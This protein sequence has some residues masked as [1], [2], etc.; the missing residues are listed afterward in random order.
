MMAE[1]KVNAGDLAWAM[2]LAAQVVEKRQTIPILA[3]VLFEAG[4]NALAITATDLDLQIRQDVPAA[5]DASF[6]VT[7]PTQRLAA[8]AGAVK[9]DAQMIFTVQD[10]GRVT[11]RSG[12]SRWV[13]A[14]LPREDF[15]C[16]P[17]ADTVAEIVLKPADL[18][19]LV[20]RVL[21]FRSTEQTRYYL[22]G[23]L[24]HGEAGK[25]ALAA[26]DGHRLMRAVLDCA[27]PDD[28]PEVILAPKACKLLATLGE[29]TADLRFAW[30]DKRIAVTIGRIEI[31]SKVIDGTFP[32][33]RRVIGAKVD[34]PLRAD[35]E[36]LRAALS[37]LMV[38]A[39]KVDSAVLIDP[40]KDGVTLSIRSSDAMADAFEEVA[41]EPGDLPATAFNARYVQEMLA[42]IGGDTVEIHMVEAGA[43]ARMVRTV[44]DGAIGTVMPMRR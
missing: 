30:N 1:L 32:D 23:P 34:A 37:R 41:C 3:N 20:N 5:C 12:R 24:W 42:A 14:T 39:D 33:Y 38:A 44:E 4:D 43:P 11:I 10:A 29:E 15:P 22:N 25:V 35:P 13:L 36:H 40:G 26:T 27:W 21:P 8:I 9:P 18:A 6:A 28:A 2:R 19:A 16:I 31:V 17:S 7:I